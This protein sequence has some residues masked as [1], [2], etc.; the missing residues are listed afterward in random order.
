MPRK[1]KQEAPPT[2]T[3]W[4]EFR[5]TLGLPE[6][7]QLRAHG[8]CYDCGAD[9]SPGPCGF[10]HSRVIEYGRV[11]YPVEFCCRCAGHG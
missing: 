5:R 11:G 10:W 4:A 8:K 7:L 2:I 6:S 9:L 3:S 1:S